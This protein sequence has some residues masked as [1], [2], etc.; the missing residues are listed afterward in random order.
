M[1]DSLWSH[2]LILITSKRC[3][4]HCSSWISLEHGRNYHE[5]GWRAH[6]YNI[7]L[8]KLYFRGPATFLHICIF[9]YIWFM[10]LGKVSSERNE[11]S[12]SLQAYSFTL[13]TRHWETKQKRWSLYLQDI[14]SDKKD[15][16]VNS[17]L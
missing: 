17:Q 5:S 7:Y 6:A 3:G 12:A 9:L 2:D 13:H 14:D 11:G 1:C 16:H 10:L 4:S 8:V 15:I